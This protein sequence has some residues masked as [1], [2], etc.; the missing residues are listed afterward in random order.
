MGACAWSAALHATDLTTRLGV[1]DYVI[2]TA[3]V[4]TL[5]LTV[6]ALAFFKDN[7]FDGDMVRGYSLPGFR[8]Q[9][10]LTFTPL[11]QIRMEAGF[12]ATVYEGANKYPSYVFHDIAH[13]KGS[14]YQHG[15]HAL[16]F[17]RAT[18]NLQPEGIGRSRTTLVLGDIYGG[19]T[20]DIL[21]PLYNPELILT[22][23]PEMGAQVIVDRKRWHSDIWLNWQSYIYEEDTHQ[24]AFTVGW[25]QRIALW[26]SKAKKSSSQSSSSSHSSSSSF[27]LPLQLV[28][29]HRGGEQ[30]KPELNLGVQTIANASAGVAYEWHSGQGASSAVT[31][32]EAEAASLYCYQQSG[33]LWPF[34][35]STA[36]W[37]G[38]SVEIKRNLTLRAGLFQAP[39]QF[40]SLYG[41]PF[42]TTVSV[43]HDDVYYDG[44]ATAY[45]DV[46][47]GKTFSLRTRHHSGDYTIGAKADGYVT[48]ATFPFSFGV[49]FR[50]TP[51]FK[52]LS[53]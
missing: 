48:R 45:W 5:G 6:D 19:A 20:H 4:R 14:Q 29:Q 15:A 9:P 42:F 39:K 49:Y 47:Y 32:V 50:V 13:W 37:M 26:Q 27:S 18:A 33:H 3:T 10:R 36:I 38:A 1:C 53:L 25:T 43:K 2:D 17:F 8:V 30:D 11:P 22:D 52:F 41:S 44:S 34:D 40:C 12:H 28:V 31:A 51:R 7:E 21:L 35:F 23:D 16:P 24:E 46:E